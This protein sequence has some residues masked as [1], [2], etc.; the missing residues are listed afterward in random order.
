MPLSWLPELVSAVLSLAFLAEIVIV[1]CHIDGVSTNGADLT[2]GLTPNALIAIFATISRLGVM[3]TLG[4]II[5]QASWLWCS[6]RAFKLRVLERSDAVLKDLQAVLLSFLRLSE[7]RGFI[8][9]EKGKK[10]ASLTSEYIKWRSS[11]ASLLIV[12]RLGFNPFIQQLLD[13]RSMSLLSS[14]LSPGRIP[15]DES[16][17]YLSGDIMEN[18]EKFPRLNPLSWCQEPWFF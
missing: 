14:S 17:T 11:L 8:G 12:L 7:A 10:F 15:R 4:S 5:T 2:A 13:T 9:L 3:I 6:K 18:G 16:Y 1:L